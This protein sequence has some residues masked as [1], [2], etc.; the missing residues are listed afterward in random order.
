MKVIY[1]WEA[2]E[3]ALRRIRAKSNRTGLA[4]RKEVVSWLNGVIESALIYLPEPK[5]G[6]KK[7]ADAKSPTEEIAT[8]L[9]SRRLERARNAPDDAVCLVCGAVKARH[10]KMGY[11]CPAIVGLPKGGMFE[12]QT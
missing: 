9:R 4:T 8:S 1:R 11:S 7:V 12:A 2:S 5:P 6:R 10:G 3:D